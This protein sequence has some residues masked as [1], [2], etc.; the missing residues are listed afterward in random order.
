[1]HLLLVEMCA[2]EHVFL[3]VVHF[4]I[5]YALWDLLDEFVML[6]GP[7]AWYATPYKVIQFQTCKIET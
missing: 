6:Q 7:S 4:G 2:R 5:L 1:M 3:R